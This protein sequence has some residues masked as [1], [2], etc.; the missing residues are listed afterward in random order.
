MQ[1]VN[2]SHLKPSTST[3][4]DMGKPSRP[5]PASGHMGW[6]AM[7]GTGGWGG[8]G[9]RGGEGD[10]EGGGGGEGMGRGRG[11]RGERG[12][13]GSCVEGKFVHAELVWLR[14]TRA[15]PL[16]VECGVD[17]SCKMH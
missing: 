2:G 14:E 9:E 13:R 6:G 8:E 4:P 17:T 16:D 7:R 1:P 10:G 5:I 11:M 3:A 15:E 12:M